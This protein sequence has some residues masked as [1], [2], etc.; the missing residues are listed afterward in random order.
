ML[1]SIGYE[2][3]ELKEF[4]S[5]LQENHINTLID[6]R[7]LPL[8]RKKGFSKKNLQ[9]N[10]NKNNIDYIHFK[11]LGSPRE[12]RNTLRKD[13]NYP[14]FFKKYSAFLKSK[15][16]TIKVLHELI[17]E[18]NCCLMCYEEWSYRCHRS[19]ICDEIKEIDGNGLKI[20]HL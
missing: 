19:I 3:K 8:S 14:N 1:F 5:I 17:T 10:L 4:I 16:N 6:V 12:L 11:E 13:R 9:E 2:S 15:N 7:E 18:N 20:K